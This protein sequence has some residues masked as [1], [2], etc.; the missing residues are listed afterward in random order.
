MI[1]RTVHFDPRF[2]VVFGP[3]ETGKSTLTSAIIASLY[4]SGRGERDSWRPWSG[5][6]YA[7]RARVRAL[8]RREFEIQRDFERDAKGVHVYDRAAMTFRANAR[9]DARRARPH[10]PGRSARGLFQRGVRRASEVAIDGSRAERIS[11]ALARALDGGPREDAALGAIARLDEAL[12]DPRRQP[13]RDGQRAAAPP[14][15]GDARSRGARRGG[16]ARLR[17]LDE[18]RGRL[19]AETRA[20]RRTRGGAARTRAPHARGSGVG[21]PLPARRVCAKFATNWPTCKQSAR[22]TTTSRISRTSAFP[23]S[24]S[25]TASGIRSKRSPSIGPPKRPKRGSRPRC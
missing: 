1:D 22:S 2:N 4:G 15:R 16:A 21:A 18:L 3:N 14:Q 11:H 12:A 13:P 9:S 24:R 5:A 25:A 17:E 8:R 23:N 10:A 6:R 7:R 19:G 20:Y